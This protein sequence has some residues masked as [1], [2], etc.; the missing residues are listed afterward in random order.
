MYKKVLIG[1]FAGLICGFFS[2]GGGMILVPSF[3]Y[4]LKKNPTESRA[5]SIC[6]ILPMVVTSSIFYYRNS[7]INFKMSL[8]CA[9]GGIF[10]GFLG[11]KLLNKIPDRILK[12][13][14]LCFLIYASIRFI[15]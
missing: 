11:A 4:V 12:I 9:L 8:L 15:L 2:T 10:G 13:V 3:M 6:C 5:T 7:Y 14:F 1:L